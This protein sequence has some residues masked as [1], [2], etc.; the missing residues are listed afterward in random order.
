M[1]G[2]RFGNGI[3]TVLLLGIMW[4]ILLGIGYLIAYGTNNSAFLWIFAA[5]GLASTFIAIG[6]RTNWQ[7]K[8]WVPTR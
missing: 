7:S 6:T 3:K 8:P 4:A 1:A 2:K 5:I